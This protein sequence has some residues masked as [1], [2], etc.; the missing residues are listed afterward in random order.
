MGLDRVADH[1]RRQAQQQSE[2]VQ[3][4]I[5]PRSRKW[6]RLRQE[7]NE[8]ARLNPVTA[9]GRIPDRPQALP[10]L[11]QIARFL[12]WATRTKPEPSRTIQLDRR[13]SLVA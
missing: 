12:E 10:S 1:G 11:P 13:L 9:D 2:A 3:V 4:G 6:L 7:F 8:E 5:E